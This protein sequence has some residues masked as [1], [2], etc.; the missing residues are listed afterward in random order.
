MRRGGSLLIVILALFGA[1]YL[2]VLYERNNCGFHLP[3]SISAVDRS[4]RCP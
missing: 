4:V 1:F 3:H 2:G